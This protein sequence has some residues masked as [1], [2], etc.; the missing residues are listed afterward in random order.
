MP[1]F[2]PTGVRTPL[3]PQS[4]THPLSA[5]S[6]ARS[7]GRSTHSSPTLINLIKSNLRKLPRRNAV[8]RAL[9]A[10]LLLTFLGLYVYSERTDRARANQLTAE[11]RE[12]AWL[13]EDGD[14]APFRPRLPAGDAH[15]WKAGGTASVSS[16]ELLEGLPV[17]PENDPHARPLTDLGREA[18]AKF[19][20]GPRT[21]KA[22]VKSLTAFVETSMPEGVQTDFLEGIQMYT[23]GDKGSLW[24]MD[25][26]GGGSKGRDT[27]WM[28]DR[29]N[30][31]HEDSA[32]VR[33]WRDNDEGWKWEMLD[34]T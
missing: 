13:S 31:G 17:F 8:Q 20:L 15:D 14:E 19:H 25:K 3:L 9:L 1:A 2:F 11:Q 24:N 6:P 30:A 32:Q 7:P 29:N 12:H 22:Y 4:A 16:A 27:I 21:L 18:D 5:V 33:S 26:F 34:D 28:T 10:L 23:A